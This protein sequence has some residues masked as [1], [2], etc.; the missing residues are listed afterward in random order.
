MQEA[1]CKHGQNGFV[2]SKAWCQGLSVGY[3]SWLL[4]LPGE[5]NQSLV[6]LG[7]GQEVRSWGLHMLGIAA[8]KLKP[9]ILDDRAIY[10]IHY[11]WRANSSQW[12][13]SK[14][15][16]EFHELAFQRTVRQCRCNFFILQSGLTNLNYLR[17][18][19]E[20]FWALCPSTKQFIY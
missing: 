4:L 20:M 8:F 1:A 14:C 3:R 13:G 17:F 12:E 7:A 11:F 6:P 9:S 10:G 16:V 5:D 15:S 2:Q 19:S 18:F